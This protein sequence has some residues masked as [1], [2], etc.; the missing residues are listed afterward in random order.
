M[1]TRHDYRIGDDPEMRQLTTLLPQGF[2]AEQVEGTMR[3]DLTV[4]R[5]AKNL[6]WL[7]TDDEQVIMLPRAWLPTGAVSG[8]TIELCMARNVGAS[9]IVSFTIAEEGSGPSEPWYGPH[10]RRLRPP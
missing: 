6:A 7:M 2:R 3:T 10:S 8:Q 1:T 4:C 9:C 5:I